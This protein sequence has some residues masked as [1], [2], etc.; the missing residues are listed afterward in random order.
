MKRKIAAFID[1][2]S[3]KYVV[4]ELDDEFEE[5]DDEFWVGDEDDQ[6]LAEILKTKKIWISLRNLHK[7]EITSLLRVGT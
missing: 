6:M 4:E 2:M 1:R 5:D 3:I 7:A